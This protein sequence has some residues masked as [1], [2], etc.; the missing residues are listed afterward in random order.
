MIICLLLQNIRYFSSW[1]SLRANNVSVA[2]PNRFLKRL[3]RANAIT[4]LA[5]NGVTGK[6]HHLD[7]SASA[8]LFLA[9][10]YLLDFC[11]T[12]VN[13]FLL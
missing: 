4:S 8:R 9:V 2:I 10:T 3:P 7:P 6:V 12:W 11:V 1:L 5:I 13:T